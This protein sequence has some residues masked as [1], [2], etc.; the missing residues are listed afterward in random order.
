MKQHKRNAWSQQQPLPPWA[1][2]SRPN[3]P[4]RYLLNRC[5]RRFFILL[6]V[7]L[8]AACLL[9]GL[10]A[11]KPWILSW[12]LPVIRHS[13]ASQ[14]DYVVHLKPDAVP[15][16]DQAPVDA[17]YLD[18][19]VT[20]VEPTF[21]TQLKTDRP[22]SARSLSF[23][24]AIIR[25]HEPG[26]GQPVLFQLSESVAEPVSQSFAGQTRLQTAQTVR[27]DLDLYRE[28]AAAI[29]ASLEQPLTY[30]LALVYQTDYTLALPGGP[31]VVSQTA[32]LIV[33]LNQPVYSIARVEEPE[34]ATHE[35]IRQVL[36]YRIY[37]TL[38]PWWVFV[39]A[40]ALILVSLLLLVFTTQSRPRDSFW[41]NLRRMKQLAS[42]R[43]MMIGDRTWDP[44]WCVRVTDYPA[45]ARTARKLKHPIFCYVDELSAWPA[46]YFYTYYGENNYCHI[47]TE[48]P[49]ALGEEL[50]SAT[51]SEPEPQEETE[52]IPFP[53]LPEEDDLPGGDNS[54]EI[55]P[56]RPVR[57]ESGSTPAAEPKPPAAEP[58]TPETPK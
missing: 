37:L 15:G 34:A 9:A 23:L 35:T 56:I 58:K 8:V 19:L 50:T 52:S 51:A 55:K 7:L 44:A 22:L 18:E 54:P 33:P 11:W 39:A 38:F 3:R 46:A 4:D 16:L 31:V 14:A 24:N 20:A 45:M 28:R 27:I 48:H 13:G 57:P 1:A 2:K 43:L 30:E 17:V 36:H 40:A 49:E 26:A 21:S 6:L 47:Y 10:I 29:A 41:R 5:W 25:A 53:V 32:S 42:G 12:K